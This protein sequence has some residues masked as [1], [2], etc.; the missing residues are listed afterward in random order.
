M[1]PA[2]HSSLSAGVDALESFLHIGGIEADQRI[3]S[4]LSAVNGFGL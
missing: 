4:D 2:A 1:K 3:L